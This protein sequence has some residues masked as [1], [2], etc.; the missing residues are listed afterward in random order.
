MIQN[1]PRQDLALKTWQRRGQSRSV[2]FFSKK[3]LIIDEE[4]LSVEFLHGILKTAGWGDIYTTRTSPDALT[5]CQNIQMDLV[6][7]NT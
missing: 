6:L 4:K 1:G 7:I 2:T 3:S 5:L